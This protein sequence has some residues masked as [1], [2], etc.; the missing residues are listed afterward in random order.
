MRC[1]RSF[2]LGLL[3]CVAAA[4]GPARAAGEDAAAHARLRTHTIVLDNEDIRPSSTTMMSDEALVFENYSLHPI[5]LRFV[6]P[7]D[8]HD[9]VRCGLIRGRRHDKSTLP[10]QLFAWDDGKLTAVI[11]PGRFASLCSFA[12]GDYSFLVAPQPFRATTRNLL[13]RK[14]ELIVK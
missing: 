13:E 4:A 9:R 6:E 3:L 10:W 8:L 11:P 7:K 5:R 1:H 14:G 12:Q 2:A